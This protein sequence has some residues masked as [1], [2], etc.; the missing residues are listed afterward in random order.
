MVNIMLLGKGGY[1]VLE[2]VSSDATEQASCFLSQCKPKQRHL[3]LVPL[4][5]EL[6]GSDIGG[7]HRRAKLGAIISKIT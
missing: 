1:L 4:T 2:N 6:L 3:V 5:L 7:G